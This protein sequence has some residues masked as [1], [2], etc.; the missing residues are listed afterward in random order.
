[1]DPVHGFAGLGHRPA[2]YSHNS[3]IALPSV[4]PVTRNVRACWSAMSKVL[5]LLRL[6]AVK[7]M[8]PHVPRLSRAL[9]AIQIFENY[10]ALN[11]A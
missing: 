7:K 3:P 10:P 8:R 5:G 4:L 2:M 11:E 9:H 1:M 6:P